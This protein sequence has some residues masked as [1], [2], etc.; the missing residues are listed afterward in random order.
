[1]RFAY[2]DPPYVGQAKKLY[3]KHPDYAG[4]VDQG[5]LIR[6][7]VD[8]Y[9]DGWALSLSASSLPA[10]LPLCPPDVR[11]MAWLKSMVHMLPGVRLQYGWEPVIMRGGRQGP[12]TTGDPM[13]KDYLVCHPQEHQYR[14]AENGHV[15]G[16]KPK[17][18]CEWLFRCLGAEP[19]DELDDVFAGTG[20][21]AE[22]WA[23]FSSQL[24]LLGQ[25]VS[26]E[27]PAPAV[28][29]PEEA[30]EGG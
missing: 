14:T 8:E 3:G 12:H 20:H 27:T 13:L 4:E 17:A 10:I 2:A 24:S 18:F 1:M 9:P 7:L 25:P 6:R 11:V 30:P 23:R 22:C 5:A 19:G 26:Q 29:V 28:L 16:R 15:I 21:V